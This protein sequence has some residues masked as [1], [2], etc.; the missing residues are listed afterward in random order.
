MTE[1]K[2]T[3]TWR[4]IGVEIGYEP[5]WLNLPDIDGSMRAHLTVRAVQPDR[6]PLPFTETGY[7]SHFTTPDAVA[8]AGGPVA[9]VLAWLDA[10][11]DTP[12]WKAKAAAAAQLCLF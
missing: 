10:E 8:S 6:A 3:F 1:E 4:G 2:H 9:Y 7:R 12:A 11:A 5:T